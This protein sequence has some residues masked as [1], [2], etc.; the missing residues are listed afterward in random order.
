MDRIFCKPIG[1]PGRMILGL[2][3]ETTL[4]V[5]ASVL[6]TLTN[7]GLDEDKLLKLEQALVHLAR[8]MAEALGEEDAAAAAALATMAAAERLRVNHPEAFEATKPATEPT[9]ADVVAAAT[10]AVN[11]STACVR[12]GGP[13]VTYK[14]GFA[15]CKACG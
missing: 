7:G 13:A 15:T 11:A 5:F 4:A 2:D 12:C 3:P 1:E 6:M 14:Q 8:R 10:A 9:G